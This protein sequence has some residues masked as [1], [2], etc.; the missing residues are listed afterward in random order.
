MFEL[1]KFGGKKVYRW[2]Q[3]LMDTLEIEKKTNNKK[4]N[5]TKKQDKNKTKM[6]QM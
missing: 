3:Q 1:I 6:R 4:L 2:L 5:L